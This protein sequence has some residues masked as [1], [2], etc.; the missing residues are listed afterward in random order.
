MLTL[1]NTPNMNSMDS[2]SFHQKPHI[3]LKILFVVM[4]SSGARVHNYFI[5]LI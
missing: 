4:H 2:T 3:T 1:I 5:V